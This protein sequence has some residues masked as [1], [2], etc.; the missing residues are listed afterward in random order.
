MP[1]T[2][3]SKTAGAASMECGGAVDINLAVAAAPGAATQRVAIALILDRSGSMAGTPMLH[4]KAGA[5]EFVNIITDAN[6]QSGGSMYEMGLISF[7]AEATTD[8]PLTGNIQTL[9]AAIEGLEAKGNTNQAGAFQQAGAM[10]Q[11]FDGK[12]VAVMF[13]DGMPTVGGDPAPQADELKAGGV[14][15]FCIGLRG[16]DGLDEDTLRAWV[17]PP[18]EDHVLLAPTASELE[19]A[20]EAL[21]RELL[22]A[23]ARNVVV[24]DILGPQFTVL[25]VEQPSVG[26][27]EAQDARTVVWRMDEL[28]ANAPQ[29]AVL[30]IAA[31]HTGEGNGNLALNEAATLTAD[32]GVSMQFAPLTVYVDCG[33]PRRDMARA[34]C[35]GG[36]CVHFGRRRGD[37]RCGHRQHGG[38]GRPADDQRAAE[39]RMPGQTHSAG[40]VGDARNAGRLPDVRLQKL[41]AAAQHRDGCA[42]YCGEG[43][44]LFAAPARAGKLQL[45]RQPVLPGVCRRAGCGRGRMPVHPAGSVSFSPAAGQAAWRCPPCV[46]PFPGGRCRVRRPPFSLGRLRYAGMHA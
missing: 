14:E 33:E 30:R 34:L 37:G 18:P 23:G 4:L 13:T 25:S 29:T 11:G 5:K 31:L 26:W 43:P 2:N 21:A 20:F 9:N 44:A 22:E 12:K 16:S 45:R 8:V 40:C 38:H 15:I 1:I 46:P 42:G 41:R 17:S 36:L 6:A 10:L 35:A 27:A 28:A 24:R 39:K 7:A 3:I 32:G 19:E